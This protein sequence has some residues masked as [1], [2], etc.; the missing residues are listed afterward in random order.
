MTKNRGKTS[1]NGEIL[2]WN[3]KIE[4]EENMRKNVKKLRKKKCGEI[5]RKKTSQT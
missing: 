1:K 4:R 5:E 3:R 2:S